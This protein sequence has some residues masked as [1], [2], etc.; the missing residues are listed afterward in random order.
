MEAESQILVRELAQS[1]NIGISIR[2][3]AGERGLDRTIRVGEVRRPGL[4]L[5]GFLR[6]Y[7]GRS[8]EVMG[9]TERLFLDSLPPAV[10]E[11]NLRAFFEAGPPAVVFSRA[12]PVPDWIL[13]AAREQGIPVFLAEPPTRELIHRLSLHL[14]RALAP[15]TSFHA[16]LMDCFGIGV[17]LMGESGVGKSETALELLHRGHRL[18]ADDVVEVRRLW[19]DLLFG[20]SPEILRHHM[21]IRGL[22][23][24]D[25]RGLFGV[26]GIVEETAIDLVVQLEPWVEGKAYDRIGLEEGKTSVLGIEVPTV[27]IPV[28]PGRNLAVL[29]EVAAM[30]QRMKSLGQHSAQE[31]TRRLRGWMESGE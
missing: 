5:A 4:A 8:L 2:L 10:R 12:E 25:V 17:L 20:T 1:E 30:N 21:E 3:L 16:V 6:H 28:Q 29:V 18:V 27:L 13:V 26:R 11:A 15:H 24:L 7:D 23:I 9:R 31:F 22:G 19:G 14:T